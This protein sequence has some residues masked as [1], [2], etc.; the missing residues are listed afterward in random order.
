MVLLVA[1]FFAGVSVIAGLI[2]GLFGLG[3]GVVLV[4]S[5][6]AGFRALGYEGPQLMTLC[7][8]TSLATV[9]VTSLR[10]G[11]AHAKRGA[12]DARLL[13]QWMLPI[14]LGA[15]AGALLAARLHSKAL[16]AIFGTLA[17]AAGLYMVLGARKAAAAAAQEPR[18][19][20]RAALGAG[21]GFGSALMGIG[22]GT[23]GVPLLSHFGHP[24]H[25]AVATAAFF[26]LA[27]ALPAALVLALT[28][29]ALAPP[30][31]L[32][33]L[34]LPS[35]ALTIAVTLV[36]APW[37][38]HLAHRFDPGPLKRLFGC[39]ILAIGARMLWQAF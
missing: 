29:V 10:A 8:G 24:I 15:V 19:G 30:G 32:G 38:V 12:V 6:Y 3:G 17:L 31:T 27:I 2:A 22:G 35:F 11:L 23:F 36:T 14:A 33:A 13:R 37:G 20:L 9:A 25:R 34:H 28:P 21:L 16:M 5:Y 39:V 7:L 26:G 4:P 18:P 1:L